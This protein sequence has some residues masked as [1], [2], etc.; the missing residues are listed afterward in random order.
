MSNIFLK[1]CLFLDTATGHGGVQI[2]IS[3]LKKGLFFAKQ[4]VT[5]G[6]WALEN[7]MLFSREAL[8]YS[9]D[10]PVRRFSPH[11]RR[12]SSHLVA[13]SEGWLALLQQGELC[14]R[15]LVAERK[16]HGQSPGGLVLAVRHPEIEEDS[17]AGG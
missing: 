7:Q 5:L 17:F 12:T 1:I 6:H 11:L 14:S 15:L 4:K 8:T 10:A 9:E 13:D 3:V 16:L 2:V